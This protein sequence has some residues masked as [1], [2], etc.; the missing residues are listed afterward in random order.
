[1]HLMRLKLHRPVCIRVPRLELI[2]GVDI[3]VRN[4][5]NS[6]SHRLR[7]CVP[8]CVIKLFRFLQPDSLEF[9]PASLLTF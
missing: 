9:I 2:T 4:L 5:G 1:M 6:P 7:T 8:F 3:V